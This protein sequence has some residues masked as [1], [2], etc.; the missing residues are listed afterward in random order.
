MG[1]INPMKEPSFERWNSG[2]S[3]E[4]YGIRN[5]G[6]EFFQISEKGEVLIYP[7][8]RDD[9][10]ALSLVDLAQGLRARGMDLPVLLRFGDILDSRVARLNDSFIKAIKQCNYQGDYRGVFPIKVNQ[11]EQVINEITKFGQAYHHGLEAG[12]K[13]EL[14]IALT[15]MHDPEAY[16][17]ATATR[18]RNSLIW[19]FTA[20]RWA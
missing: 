6:A 20:S 18:I 15:Y 10:V 17:S 1:G 12:S 14:M 8:G 19:R 3:A 16:I 2:K 13:A 5:W 11:Q 9:D 4:L 7:R